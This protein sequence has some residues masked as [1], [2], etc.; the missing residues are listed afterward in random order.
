MFSGACGAGMWGRFLGLFLELYVSQR[1]RGGTMC[2]LSDWEHSE[3]WCLPPHW[4]HV[5]LSEHSDTSWTILFP[6]V[7]DTN[8][9]LHSLFSMLWATSLRTTHRAGLNSRRCLVF[10][11][12]APASLGLN[13]TWSRSQSNQASAYMPAPLNIISSCLY[14]YIYLMLWK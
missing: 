12:P 10:A 7:C 2:W 9:S 1:I 5:G 8:D 14:L 13:W 6:R 4:G 3:A 11:A